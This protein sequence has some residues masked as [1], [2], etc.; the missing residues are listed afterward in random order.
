MHKIEFHIMDPDPVPPAVIEGTM[1]VVIPED[2][3]DIMGVKEDIKGVKVDIREVQVD[4][5]V[6]EVVMK[7]KEVHTRGLPVKYQHPSKVLRLYV[8]SVGVLDTKV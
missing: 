5:K 6:N 8:G 4:I 1:E 2:G 7:V 3:E